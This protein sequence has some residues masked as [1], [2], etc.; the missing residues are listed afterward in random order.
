MIE[1]MAQTSTLS[2]Y[3]QRLSS[4]D[5]AV[6][7]IDFNVAL[8]LGC[9]NL[10][11]ET[12]RQNAVSL[13]LVA[14]SADMPVVFAGGDGETP[15]GPMLPELRALF[16]D[17]EIVERYTVSAWDE[18]RF[19]D[20]IAATGRRKLVMAGIT[21]DVCLVGPALGA[22][23]DGY[24]VYVPLDVCGTWDARTEWTQAIRLSQAGAVV[25]NWISV[26]GELAVSWGRE[27]G[28]SLLRIMTDRFGPIAM[29]H[30]TTDLYPNVW[31]PSVAA[32]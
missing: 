24:D 19:R 5:A 2:R 26:A 7:F 30:Q 27:P 4:E 9:Q 23:S 11:V 28:T 3:R 15:L 18:P 20:A 1:Q 8:M 25:T 31:K 17:S 21:S 12:L 14:R 29:A 6:V 13:G 16:P 10:P 22:L 32:A